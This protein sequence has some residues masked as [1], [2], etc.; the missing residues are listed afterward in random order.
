MS[1]ANRESLAFRLSGSAARYP[2]LRR[3]DVKS[4]TIRIA[5]FSMFLACSALAQVDPGVR[6]S[7]PIPGA[8]YSSVTAN[9]PAGILKFFQNAQGR[10]TETDSGPGT[11]NG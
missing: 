9:N 4:R 11:V 3:S 2:V 6:T 1:S 5:S 7:G 8:T 10:F